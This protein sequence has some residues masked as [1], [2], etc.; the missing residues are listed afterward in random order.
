TED[1]KCDKCSAIM[2]VDDVDDLVGELHEI[3]GQNNTKVEF[4]SG[5]S[6]EGGLLLKAFGGIAGILR[7]R[8]S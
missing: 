6:E 2:K 7:F 5:E 4:V 1:V 8:V 3:A